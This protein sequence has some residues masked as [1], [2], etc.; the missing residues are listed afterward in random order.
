MPVMLPWL[1]IT[2]GYYGLRVPVGILRASVRWYGIVAI[3][4]HAI[5]QQAQWM[6]SQANTYHM[7]GMG[8]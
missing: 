4:Y 5:I 8:K 3:G 1:Q 7:Y 6:P 2:N